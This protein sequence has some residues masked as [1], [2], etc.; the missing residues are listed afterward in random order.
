MLL[1]NCFIF[2]EDFLFGSILTFVLL[3]KTLIASA[4]F[5]CIPLLP[6]DSFFDCNTT[7]GNLNI[8]FYSNCTQDSYPFGFIWCF[9]ALFLSSSRSRLF[10]WWIS[11]MKKQAY[12]FLEFQPQEPFCYL[13]QITQTC[14]IFGSY[15][16]LIISLVVIIH[17]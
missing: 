9:Y 6:N 13:L 15:M 17:A 2:W 8:L 12:L 3:S 4:T 16:M 14:D 10:T 5:F 11:L 1:K 7:K